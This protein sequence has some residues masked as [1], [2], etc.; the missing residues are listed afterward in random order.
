MS[1]V[2]LLGLLLAS[3]SSL[4]Q[5]YYGMTRHSPTPAWLPR[6]VFLGT[7]LAQDTVTPL[8]RLGWEITLNQQRGDALVVVGELGGG[9]AAVTSQRV[10]LY[11]SDR[12]ESLRHG[13]AA[14]GIAYRGDRG[15]WN[16][17]VHAT[18]G[19]LWYHA[20]LST[21]PTENYVV[22]WI[23]G[24]AQIGYRIG[25]VATGISL[26]YGSG[27]SEPVRSYTYRFTGGLMLGLYANWR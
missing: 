8:G 18:V 12:V 13:L 20:R 14:V 21:L 24:R 22:G 16:W 19:P 9:A 23:E 11:G 5:G 27:F 15:P 17:G 26:G 3:G 2:L 6:S 10:G 25:K 7:G 4:A 1:R